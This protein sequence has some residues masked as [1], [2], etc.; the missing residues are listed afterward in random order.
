MDFGLIGYQI[1][2]LVAFRFLRERLVLS[3]E[4]ITG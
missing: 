4:E 3:S 2:D 1:W